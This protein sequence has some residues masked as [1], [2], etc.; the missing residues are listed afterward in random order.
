MRLPNYYEDPSVVHVGTMENRAYYIPFAAEET[1]LRGDRTQSERVLLL[2]GEWKFRYYAGIYD[3]EEDFFAPEFSADS[4][5]T[6]SVPSCWQMLGYDHHQYTNVRY[7]FPYD[8]PY[9][10]TENPCGAY[11]R[12]FVVTPEQC[13]GKSFLNFEGVDSCY[14]VWLNGKRV[15]YS[16]VSHSTSEFDI[17]DFVKP[18]EN[19]IAVLVLKWCDG[20]YLEDQDKLRMSG[21]FRDVYILFRPNSHIRDYFV[22]T[23]PDASYQNAEITVNL[24]WYGTPT[25]GTCTLLSPSGEV[26][27]V[28]DN[29]DGKVS[30]SVKDALLWNAETPNLYRLAMKTSDEVIV[31]NVGIKQIQVRNRILY[32]NGEKIKLKGVNRHDSDPFT[33]YTISKEQ[34][35]ADLALMKQHNINAIRTSHYPN[36]PW[37]TQLY[38][39]YGFYVIS[40]SDIETHGTITVYGGGHENDYE[41]M[42]C[43]DRTFGT[44]C[45]D[46]RFETA[47]L[48]R[49]QKNVTRDKNCASVFMW[50]LGNE[51]GYGPNM[52]KAAAWIKSYDPERLV[53]YESSVYEMEGYHNDLSNID[54]Y[55]RMYAPVEAIEKYFAEGLNKPFLQCEFSHAMG[56]GPGDLEN[57]YQKIYQY[58]QFAGGFVWEWCDH[59]V[60]AGTTKEGKNKFYYGGDFGEFPHDGNFCV[61]GLVYPD[62]RAHSGLKEL[63]NVARPARAS[64]VNL[65]KG[66][67]SIVNTLDFTN[68]SDCLYAEYQITCNGEVIA[69]GTVPDLDI[70]PKTEK[71]VCLRYEMPQ[72]G[73]CYLTIFYKQKQD[74]D[75]VKAGYELGFDQ[76]TL[77]ES[78]LLPCAGEK[79]KLTVTDSEREIIVA[80]ETFHYVFNKLTGTFDSLVK[81]NKNILNQPMEYNL[82]RAPT[83]N[84]M[85][86][87]K[88]WEEAGYNRTVIRVYDVT[89]VQ[90]E[91]AAVILADL[92]VSAISV[93]RILTVKSEWTV[94]SDGRISVHLIADKTPNLPFLPRFGLRLFLPKSFGKVEYFG[95]GPNESYIDK[96]RSSYI[97][98]FTCD[99]ADMYEDYIKPQENFSHYGCSYAEIYD[100]QGHSLKAFGNG[101]SF[102][103]SE[104][105]Q[106]ELTSK[107][108][109][110]ELEKCG[111]AVLCLDY[112]MSG[113]GSN[114]CGPA[115]GQAYRFDEEHFEYTMDL[116]IGKHSRL[117]S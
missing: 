39:R 36:S 31:Q 20:S 99:I 57:Y 14:Y 117:H 25:E 10:P 70:P 17:S 60:W 3:V 95:Y 107:A 46:P 29:L 55:S 22:R 103:A 98:K 67:V 111:S 114:S 97:G 105:T 27:G 63:K 93:Q 76:L 81:D 65:E 13:A 100:T 6:I 78:P 96:H 1:A 9:V 77:C 42:T 33:G 51:S 7:P 106:E 110:F 32:L 104:Y 50:S 19:T 72:A 112:K 12:T 89:A 83:D 113:V 108:H 38:D 92:A 56:N 45:H 59:A 41:K 47:F 34:L 115:L 75:F 71:T 16:Q 88:E 44:L 49:V 23:T 58:D 15:G 116:V 62:R 94:H 69:Q 84:D 91:K 101:F 87:R 48:D 79:Q 8:P 11:V 53:H 85:Y 37:A 24:E 2:S 30:F 43:K 5:D 26:L 74:S 109:N 18:G 61:D 21:I 40:E 82:W 28:Q 86:I 4:F 66:L 73:N 54:V 64:A 80:G 52:E 90:N 68:L 102:H 35:C